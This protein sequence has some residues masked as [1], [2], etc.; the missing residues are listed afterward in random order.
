MGA[1]KIGK[2]EI[3]R[4]LGRGAMGIVYEGH[5]PDIGR[6]VAIKTIRFDV[7]RQRAEQDEAQKRFMREARS[8]GNLSHPNIVTIYDVGQDE[9]L[10]YIAMEYI[11]GESL[12]AMIAEGRR[13]ELEAVLSLIG[14]IG[15]ALDFAH[16]HG[17]IH[18]DIKPGNILIDKDGWPRLLDFGIARVSSSTMTQTNMVMGTPYYMAP[19]QI[20]GKTVDHRADIFSLGTILYEILT[21]TKPF[22]GENITTVIYRILNE[23][24]PEPRAYDQNLP[25]GL[26]YVVKK[27]LAKN[28]AQ[29]YQSCRELADDLRN[30]AAFEGMAFA[31]GAVPEASEAAL[32]QAEPK[33][34][35]TLLLIVGAMMAVV[36]MAAAVFLLTGKGSKSPDYAGGGGA[37]VERP[38]VPP[39]GVGVSPKPE[40]RESGTGAQKPDLEKTDLSAKIADRETPPAKPTES[41]EQKGIQTPDKKEEEPVPK[42]DTKTEPVKIEVSPKTAAEIEDRLQLVQT[43]FQKEAYDKCLKEARKILALDPAHAEAKKYLDMATLKYAPIQFQSLINVYRESV[44]RGALIEFFGLNGTPD[45]YNEIKAEIQGWLND[46]VE[47]QVSLS[48]VTSQILDNRDGSYRAELIFS[49]ILTALSRQKK[50][51]VVLS[52][53]RIRWDLIQVAEDWRIRKITRLP[54]P[55]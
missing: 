31:G 21:L 1:N 8:A 34:R 14:Q 42:A 43:A 16:R 46:Y 29:R 32:P 2:Y 47:F 28:P 5:D 54:S 55:K 20:A 53:G 11:E 13:P 36:A 52:E 6:K 37:I 39:S 9:G 33:P 24:P 19:E 41:V 45:F 35:K 25:A 26:D 50:S 18:R 3:L 15:D 30:S 17:I 40:T 7:I 49:E 27:A 48:A 51:R 38:G 22:P 10:T 44:K 4:E 23:E 12:E